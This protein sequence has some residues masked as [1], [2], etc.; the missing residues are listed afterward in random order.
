[1]PFSLILEPCGFII[2]QVLTSK[3][4]NEADDQPDS[5]SHR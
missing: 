4:E 3:P 5:E 1:M 2:S